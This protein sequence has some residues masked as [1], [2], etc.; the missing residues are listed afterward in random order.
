MAPAICYE[1]L[2]PEHADRA[3]NLGAEVYVASVAKPY[4]SLENANDY[5][6]SLASRLELPVLLVNSV[7]PQEDF[8]SGG[9]SAVWTKHGQL[10]GKLDVNEEGLLFVNPFE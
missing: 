9:G 4:D 3:V 10:K 2:Q 7:G 6:S 5:Y 8:I 1:S